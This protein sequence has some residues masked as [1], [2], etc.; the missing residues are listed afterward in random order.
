MRLSV[1]SEDRKAHDRT[2]RSVLRYEQQGSDGSVVEARTWALH[3]YTPSGFQELAETAGLTVT[4]RHDA[5]GRSLPVD[6]EALEYTFRL[7]VTRAGG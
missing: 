5:H 1:L 6:T 3:W 2:L 4:G 7:Q